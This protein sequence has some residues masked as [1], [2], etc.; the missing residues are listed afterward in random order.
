MELPYIANP[1]WSLAL[2]TATQR[3]MDIGCSTF[4]QERQFWWH[5]TGQVAWIA[6]KHLSLVRAFPEEADLGWSLFMKIVHTS[7]KEQ[8]P[9]AALFPCHGM[10][11]GVVMIY[12]CENVMQW[13]VCT[14]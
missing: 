1:I 3:L 5:N 9:Q 2:I 13:F 7:G 11:E 8:A 12:T 10:R 4:L 6:E 14:I